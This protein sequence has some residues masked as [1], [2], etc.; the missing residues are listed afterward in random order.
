MWRLTKHLSRVLWRYARPVLRVLEIA[1]ALVLRVLRIRTQ[2]S[3][4]SR[5]LVRPHHLRRRDALLT[6]L[7][8]GCD[9]VERVGAVATAAVRHAGHHE[10]ASEV[11]LIAHLLHEVLVIEHGVLRRDRRI[12]PAGVEE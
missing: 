2:R 7:F 3:R 11:L 10:Q 5:T 1:R 8:H 9:R 12:S 6:P 4:Q